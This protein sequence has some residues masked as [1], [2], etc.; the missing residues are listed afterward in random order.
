MK[1][2]GIEPS[3]K[4]ARCPAFGPVGGQLRKQPKRLLLRSG[5]ALNS[6][7]IENL[8]LFLTVAL[9]RLVLVR[10]FLEVIKLWPIVLCRCHV[11]GVDG[12]EVNLG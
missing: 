4:K 8:T 6:K 3:G 1:P 9:T 2:R 5:L 10:E 12:M 7:A 11:N